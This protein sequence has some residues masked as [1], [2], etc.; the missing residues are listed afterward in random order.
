MQF[1]IDILFHILNIILFVIE[2]VVGVIKT[3]FFKPNGK[4]SWFYVIGFAI[5]VIVIISMF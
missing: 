1:L 3:V 2:F 4:I 5:L